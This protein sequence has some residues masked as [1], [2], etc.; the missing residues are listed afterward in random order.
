MWRYVYGLWSADLKMHKKR[1][2]LCFLNS[3]CHQD[4]QDLWDLKAESGPVSLKR[5]MIWTLL[6][7]WLTCVKQ[8]LKISFH[9]F[10]RPR[11]LSQELSW[12]WTSCSCTERGHSLHNPTVMAEHIPSPHRGLSAWLCTS[13]AGLSLW[14]QCKWPGK[15]VFWLSCSPFTLNLSSQSNYSQ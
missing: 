5:P 11:F 15:P 9:S 7:L 2:I 1:V 13:Y 8:M 6:T 3:V 4:P 10:P 14:T 12:A